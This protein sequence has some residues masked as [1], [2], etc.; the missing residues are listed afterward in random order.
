MKE[1]FI[2]NQILHQDLVLLFRYVWC[3]PTHRWFSPDV[4]AAMLKHRTREKKVFWEFDSIIMPNM[5]QICLFETVV[6][7]YYSFLSSL[8]RWGGIWR[9]PRRYT[10]VATNNLQTDV[11]LVKKFDNWVYDDYGIEQRMPWISGAKLTTS[12]NAT[13]DRQWGTLIGN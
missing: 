10:F 3:L 6:L 1:K 2:A 9:A 11:Q 4:I 8:G 13:G 5:S 7:L 12:R